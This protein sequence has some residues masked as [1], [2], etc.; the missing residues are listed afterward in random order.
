MN[1]KRCWYISDSVVEHVITD[2]Y[3]EYCHSLIAYAEIMARSKKLNYYSI[4]ACELSD[5]DYNLRRVRADK[6]RMEMIQKNNRVNKFQVL[7]GDNGN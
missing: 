4:G 3:Q 7:E 2:N 6:A 1:M 5:E